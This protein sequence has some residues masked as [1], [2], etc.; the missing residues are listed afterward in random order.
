MIPTQGQT[1]FELTGNMTI[2]GVTKEVHFRELRRSGATQRLLAERRR[3]LRCTFGLTKPSFAR[4][5][6]VDDKIQLEVASVQT[7]LSLESLTTSPALKL[8][9]QATF[10]DA[11]FV[12]APGIETVGRSNLL[13]VISTVIC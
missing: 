1:G 7:K 11:R 12:D 5:M 2:H 9:E 4:L 3:A 6:S 8:S 10:A 13:V